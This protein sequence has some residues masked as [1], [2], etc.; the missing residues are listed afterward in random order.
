MSKCYDNPDYDDSESNIQNTWNQHPKVEQERK[1]NFYCG[2]EVDYDDKCLEQCDRCV[3]ATGVD[4][5]YLPEEETK[6]Y[7]GHTTT[8]DCGPEDSKQNIIDMMEGDE[9]LGLYDEIQ[10]EQVWNEEKKKGIKQLIQ[11]HKKETLKEAAERLFP[12]K[13]EEYDIFLIGARWQQERMYSEEDMREAF[14]YGRMWDM[15]SFEEWF[16]QFK[17]K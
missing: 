17:K 16:E 14:K 5:G 12:N 10:P 8:C 2:D 1:K 15:T 3:D 13:M 9:E 6:C 4:Y 7:C 11:D